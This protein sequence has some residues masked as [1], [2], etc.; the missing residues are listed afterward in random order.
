MLTTRC[1]CPYL[2]I[3]GMVLLSEVRSIPAGP[4]SLRGLQVREGREVGERKGDGGCLG[5]DVDS[6]T[7]GRDKHG[8]SA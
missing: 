8:I 6:D 7:E 2:G 3:E 5:S 4:G 1:L